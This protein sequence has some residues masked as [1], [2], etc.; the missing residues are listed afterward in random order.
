MLCVTLKFVVWSGCLLG[1]Y[2]SLREDLLE[3]VD[4]LHRLP[5]HV[6]VRVQ[7]D[8]LEDAGRGGLDERRRLFVERVV[9][10]AVGAAVEREFQFQVFLVLPGGEHAHAD[11]GVGEILQ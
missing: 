9:Q 7:P 1:G 10:R 8:A 5:V 4:E 2:F 6:H 11:P 3:V